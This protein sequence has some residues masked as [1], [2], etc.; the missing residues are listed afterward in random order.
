[1]GSLNTSAWIKPI[2]PRTSKIQLV[3][4]CKVVVNLKKPNLLW[5]I[6]KRCR[7]QPKEEGPKEETLKRKLKETSLH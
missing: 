7:S 2:S 6:S 1:M 3:V 4:V 5:V